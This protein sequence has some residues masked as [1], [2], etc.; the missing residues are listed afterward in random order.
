MMSI[1]QAPVL[2]WFESR[3]VPVQTIA[4]KA[5]D[6]TFEH[7]LGLFES[8]RGEAGKIPLWPHHKQRLMESANE[9]K[10]PISLAN[11]PELKDLQRLI[12]HSGLSQSSARLRLTLTGGTPA[13]PCKI[14]V[15]CHPL[16]FVKTDG[17]ILA[18]PF[19]PVD[20]RD[21]LVCHKT[22]NYWL[23]RNAFEAAIA[24]GADESL[25]QDSQGNLWE[26]SR[27][28]LFLVKAGGLIAPPQAGP[29]LQSIA[30]E[31]LID[32]IAH[33]DDLSITFQPITEQ[34]LAE[35]DEV[36]LANALRGILTVSQWRHH[37]FTSP[38]PV[39]DT[40]RKAWQ[41]STF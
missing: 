23:R 41:A 32:L 27:T 10:L 13:E 16:G 12:E 7:G 37:H 11:L 36:V 6:Q 30:A 22:L 28:A 38:G 29:R 26:G 9:L 34:D 24:M 2:A 3:I 18:D 8:M 20:A 35:A 15:S 21:P 25:S 39:A 17:L 5:S 1:T 33:R 19:W 14:W 31:L 4:V 40:I